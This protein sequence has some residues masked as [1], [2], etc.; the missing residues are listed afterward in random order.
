[1]ST[2]SAWLYLFKSSRRKENK[3]HNYLGGGFKMGS[4]WFY[5]EF[6]LVWLSLLVEAGYKNPAIFALEYT[7]VP[8]GSYPT[9]LNEVAAG[10]RY[11]LHRAKS[12][13][14]VCISGDSAGAA[15]VLSFLRRETKTSLQRVAF[16]RPSVAVLISPW[17]DLV[18]PVHKNSACDYLDS[19][20][21]HR[22]AMEYAGSLEAATMDK[23]SPGRCKDGVVW[24]KQSPT[25]GYYITYGT[26]EVFAEDIRGFIR[27]LGEAKIQVESR[28][29]AGGVHAWPV[30]S[31]FLS[32]SRRQR[33][34]GLKA[35][36]KWLRETI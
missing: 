6:L 10:Y 3:T 12:P 13:L 30:A 31:L 11:V 22:Y 33:V 19:N 20:T 15:L 14:R 1:M 32:T 28:Q 16:P 18:S 24:G 21:L 4:T 35:I 9:Q 25:K 27:L 34:R 17:V 36:V 5:L 29:E 8:D 23:V 2:V 7:L 26:E